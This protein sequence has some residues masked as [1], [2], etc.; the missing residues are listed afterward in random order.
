[1]A[2]LT[3]K[4]SRCRKNKRRTHWVLQAPNLNECPHCHK[5]KLSH[6]VCPDCGYYKGKAVKQ[7]KE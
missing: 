6:R 2:N 4:T 3:N 7:V 1:M 5:P